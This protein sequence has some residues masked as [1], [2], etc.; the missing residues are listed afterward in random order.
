[1]GR[2]TT[3]AGSSGS[4]TP[5]SASVLR[6]AT[7]SRPGPHGSCAPVVHYSI[8]AL[9]DDAMIEAFGFPRPLPGTR[10]LI[11]GALRGRGMLMRWLPPRT[12]PHFFT[13]NRNR[14]YPEGYAIGR[15]GPPRLVAKE[16]ERAQG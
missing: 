4:P 5:I 2:A 6:R 13:D 3:N 1:M 10:T 8:Y 14:T 15:L 12:Q 11:G 16:S 7:C 9:L